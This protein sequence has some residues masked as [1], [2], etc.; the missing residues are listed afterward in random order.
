VLV[1][2]SLRTSDPNIYAIG[3]I[4]AH[5]HP[6]LGRRI[7]VEHWAAAL[8]Q[9]TAVATSLTGGDDAEYRELPYFFSDQYDLG[10]EYL[11]HAASSARVV[12]RGDLA[13]REFVA[14]WLDADD[15]LL[16]VMNVNVWDVPDAVKPFIGK[17]VDPARLTDADV[18]FDELA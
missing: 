3:D 2:G 16:A 9:P 17:R 12:V 10:M 5:D 4:A 15:R 8:N 13:A 7:R 11:G 1:D 14:F 6:V 18:P